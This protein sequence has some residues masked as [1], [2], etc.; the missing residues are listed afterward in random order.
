MMNMK[1]YVANIDFSLLNDF[2]SLSGNSL[3]IIVY[4]WLNTE[5]S[6][7]LKVG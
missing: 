4:N 6:N 5:L 7:F 1:Y 3:F 2:P